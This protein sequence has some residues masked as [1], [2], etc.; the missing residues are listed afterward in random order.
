MNYIADF[1]LWLIGFIS[2][3]HQQCGQYKAGTAGVLGG[4]GRG[5][6]VLSGGGQVR[7]AGGGEGGA[8][9][10]VGAGGREVGL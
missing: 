4:A 1:P 7:G 9:G 5:G 10:R 3:L 8:N 6:R 2:D